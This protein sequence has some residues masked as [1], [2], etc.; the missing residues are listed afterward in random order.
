VIDLRR[1]DKTMLDLFIL[2]QSMGAADV[3][4]HLKSL[5][6]IWKCLSNNDQARIGSQLA[7]GA[8]EE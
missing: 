8:D 5:L 3:S 6:L 4:G 7:S 2:N 1:I